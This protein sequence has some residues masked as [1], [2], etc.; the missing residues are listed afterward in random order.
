MKGEKIKYLFII[1]LAISFISG[2][3]IPGYS[4]VPRTINYQGYLTDSSGNP[5]D[6]SVSIIFSLY[7]VSR[8][9]TVLWSQTQVVVVNQGIYNVVLGGGTASKPITLPFDKPYYLG[10]KVGSDSEMDPRQPLTSVPYALNKPQL[11][12]V[13]GAFENET[14]DPND[15][16]Y[17]LLITNQKNIVISNSAEVFTS[18]ENTTDIDPEK[19]RWGLSCTEDW[20]NTG[21]VSSSYSNPVYI[22]V[23][24]SQY[25]NGCHSDNEEYG[26]VT[27]FTTCCKIVN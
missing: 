5:I 1:L 4:E 21:C 7:D 9:G 16:R 12:C 8:S 19:W 26:N 15:I 14:Y 11:A 10:V 13:T 25:S 6:G 23:D 3:P 18:Y 2:I 17:R 27:I 20:A 24:V 22:D